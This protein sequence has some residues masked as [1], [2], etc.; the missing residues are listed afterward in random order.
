VT[1]QFLGTHTQTTSAIKKGI[2]VL[3]VKS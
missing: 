3:C 1:Q 2:K